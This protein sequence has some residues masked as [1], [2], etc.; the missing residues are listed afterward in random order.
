MT[1]LSI[2]SFTRSKYTEKMNRMNKLNTTLHKYESFEY[3]FEKDMQTFAH[4][5]NTEMSINKDSMPWIALFLQSK[6]SA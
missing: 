4:Y 6:N 3:E 5:Y 2:K 1:I